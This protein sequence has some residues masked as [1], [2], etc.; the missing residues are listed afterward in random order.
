GDTPHT[1]NVIPTW[2][3]YTHMANIRHLYAAQRPQ[4]AALAGFVQTIMQKNHQ[5]HSDT[6][7]VYPFLLTGAAT[8]VPDASAL[9]LPHARHFE[10]MGQ[11]FMRSGTGVDDTYSLFTCGGILAQHRHFDALNLVIYH[12]GH[13]AL[14][15]GTR[16]RET[17]NGQHLAN[18]YAQTVAHNCVLI[19]QPDEP[20][21]RYWGG[22]VKQMH[23]GQH[24]QLGS[25]L[26]AFE[27]NDRFVY[28]AGDATA[29]YQHKGKTADGKR[30]LPQKADLVTRQ[31]V[32][33]MPNHLVVFD[34]VRATDASYRKEW[35]L[36]SAQEPVIDGM[37]VR[38][39]QGG[40]RLF[41]RTL[42]PR[43]ARIVKVGRPA[44][45]FEA[46][47]TNWVVTEEKLKPKQIAM[48]GQWR[49]EVS[50]AEARE[51]DF[52]LHVLQVGPTSL[53]HPSEVGL[54]TGADAVGAKVITETGVWEVLFSTSGTLGGHIRCTGEG[55]ALD[56]PLAMEVLSQKGITT[57]TPPEQ[58]VPLSQL[59]RSA[60]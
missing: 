57:V 23:G 46:G 58:G 29:C 54:Q 52:F 17:E 55:M 36:H 28:V 1:T 39:D 37:L 26:K 47:G 20:Y 13:L 2:Q 14:D 31:I 12:R 6:W 53:E 9:R 11:V 18:Y 40:G 43:A 3:L 59:R 27:T 33:L 44:H 49:V 5:R 56:R 48:M 34:R 7:F 24:K 32:F 50:P 10:N 4:A 51:D 41:C 42:L 60:E 30:D 38:A 35:L 8:P 19:H 15:S 21:A 25:V 22:K 16:Y 45:K